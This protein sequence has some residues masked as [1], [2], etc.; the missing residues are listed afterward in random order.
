MSK[1]TRILNDYRVIY[2]PSEESAMTSDNW[3][4]YIY[5]HVYIAEKKIGRRLLE[6][7]VV[8]HLDL[9]RS[10][11]RE[12]NLLVLD[13]R[14]HNTIHAWLDRESMIPTRRVVPHR[15]CAVCDLTLQEGQLLT[16]SRECYYSNR[17]NKIEQQ[18]G[19][20]KPNKGQLEKDIAEMSWTA[21]GRKY[22]VSDNG[23]RK[24]AKGYSLL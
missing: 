15:Y 24:W 3:K 6:D 5:E 16:C 14:M 7:E 23:A 4:G 17:D 19:C 8:H 22:N 20:P 18:R 13:K 12:E 11:N 2:R 9:D 1:S 10:N 21:I